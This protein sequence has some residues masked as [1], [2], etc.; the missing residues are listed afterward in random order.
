MKPYMYTWWQR[1]ACTKFI[2]A[3]ICF[4][5]IGASLLPANHTLNNY[6]ALLV[7][8]LL[9]LLLLYSFVRAAIDIREYWK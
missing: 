6:L 2:A 3:A 8:I 1:P 5:Y 7:L 4:I 9:I